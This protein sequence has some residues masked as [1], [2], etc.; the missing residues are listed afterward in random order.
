[1]REGLPELIE[2][3][4]EVNGIDDLSLTTN[5][6]FLRKQAK[7]LAQAGLH[8]VN[9]S[10][11][12]LSDEI[13]GQMNG[14]QFPVARVLEGIESA[15]SEGLSVKI[16][17]MVQRGKNDSEILPM[18]RF[19]RKR[20]ITLR[21]IEYMDVGNSNKWIPGDVY[22]AKE[23]ISII[24]SESPLEPL[25][26]NYKGEVASRYRYVGTKTEIGIISSI[27]SPF[28]GDC[29]RARLSA[30]GKLFTCLFAQLGTDFRSVLRRGD[31]DEKLFSLL[32]RVW[33]LRNDRYSEIRSEITKK[34]EQEQKI[35]M[36]Y[37]GG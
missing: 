4:G 13:F 24:H 3:I 36:S 7:A 1:M 37:I 17:M 19:F 22:P 33:N 29:H 34:E 14:R 26:P 21:F 2:K 27:T 25:Q 12:S 6:W 11:D 18:A 23:I 28:C 30:D 15:L 32:S 20:N 8:R 10:L 16:N 35:E 9:V 31:S 5:A